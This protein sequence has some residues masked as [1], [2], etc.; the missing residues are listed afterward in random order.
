MFGF[1]YERKRERKRERENYPAKVAAAKGKELDPDQLITETAYI[2]DMFE[3]IL[4]QSIPSPQTLQLL[5]T[6]HILLV[7]LR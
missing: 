1:V 4:C 5:L 2:H 3:E 6:D 7:H